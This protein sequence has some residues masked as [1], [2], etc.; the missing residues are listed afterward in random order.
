[1]SFAE[2]AARHGSLK[3]TV[4]NSFALDR[5]AEHMEQASQTSVVQDA[6]GNF[7]V[8]LE[9]AASS[10]EVQQVGEAVY[11][12]YD[13]GSLRQKT[14]RDLATVPL[15]E[16][17]VSALPQALGLFAGVTFTDP[18][19]DHVEGRPATRYRLGLAAAPRAGGA[20]AK[21]AA[22]AADNS[23]DADDAGDA[24]ALGSVP[25]SMGSEAT[26]AQLPTGMPWSPPPLWHQQ[27]QPLALAGFVSLDVQNGTLLRALLD[28]R[29]QIMDRGAAS[30]QL[31]VHVD[32]QVAQA[33]RVE[34]LLA[35]Q[36]ALG[37]FRRPLRVH[38][39][40][41]FFRDQLPREAPTE[42]R[43]EGATKAP[44]AQPP[45]ALDPLAD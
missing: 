25:G 24:T 22:G 23:G 30:T 7:R 35:P 37:E 27:L 44:D 9:N 20:G 6:S 19:P 41:S 36:R 38:D 39:P 31:T 34:P 40:L 4:R 17:V 42:L 29:L 2:M 11:V 15:R 8:S 21:S 3:A 33:G 1:M 14:R 5:T 45:A 28:G 16:T 10:L 18:Q 26:T 32:L 43:H 12:R 13:R